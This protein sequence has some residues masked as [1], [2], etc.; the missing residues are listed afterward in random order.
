MNTG[1]WIYYHT[2]DKKRPDSIEGNPSPYFRKEFRVR[3]KVLNAT[4]SVATVGVFKAFLNGINVSDEYFSSGRCDFNK[5]IPVFHYD[6]TELLKDENAIGIICGDG[7]AIGSMPF[8]ESVRRNCFSDEIYLWAS[9]KISYEDGAE[10]YIN[11][12][13]TWKVS[14]GKIRYSSMYFGECVDSNFDLTDGFSEFGF[15]A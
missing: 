3:G 1:K 10:V 7:W 6:V 8:F 13:N 12:D 4:L 11:T 2:G 9:L 15:N 14:S 5:R